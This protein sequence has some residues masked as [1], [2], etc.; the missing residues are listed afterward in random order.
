MKIISEF[1]KKVENRRAACNKC[2]HRKVNGVGIETCGLCGCIISAKVVTPT[3][4][5]PDNPP[6]WT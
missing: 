6:R 3:T 4:Q 5:C 1:N 2:P